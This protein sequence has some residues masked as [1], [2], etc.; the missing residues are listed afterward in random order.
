MDGESYLVA[1]NIVEVVFVPRVLFPERPDDPLMIVGFI[2]LALHI[3]VEGFDV[4]K[5]IL[6][7]SSV[8]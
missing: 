7:N 2:A 6:Y 1:T 5:E 3:R 8:G 4:R